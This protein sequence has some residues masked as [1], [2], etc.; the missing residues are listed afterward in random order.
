MSNLRIGKH[1]YRLGTVTST[2]EV[3]KDLFLE[4][5]P[6]GTIVVAQTQTSG[7]GR[8]ERFWD[9]QPGK[10]LWMSTLLVPG[11]PEEHWS[12]VSFWS[13]IAARKAAL[14]LLNR[15]GEFEPGRL[16]LKW[17]N[18]LLLDNRKLGG[19]LAEKTS[20][21]KGN[22]AIVLG[23]GLNLLHRREDFPEALRDSAASILQVTG[24]ECA[25]DDALERVVHAII[26][27]SPLVHP[28]NPG[29]IEEV[30]L[31]HAWALNR[32][33]RLRSGEEVIE[34]LF[35]G[36]GRYGEICLQTDA[37]TVH[38]WPNADAIELLEEP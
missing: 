34:G 25:P 18:D 10:G 21:R 6:E 22:S 9:S 17:P 2:Q 30:W 20:D 32:R 28:V 35:T 12:W 27:L 23:V 26:N 14:E 1:L 11:G 29:L 24:R 36:L 19:I 8:R 4:G 7:R 16:R 33:L 13:G 38:E 31:N 37:G 3:L 5:A 15:A